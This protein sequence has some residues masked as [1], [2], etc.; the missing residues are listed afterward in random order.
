MKLFNSLYE[1]RNRGC[2]NRFLA[3]SDLGKGDQK[4]RVPDVDAGAEAVAD[5]D[6]GTVSFESALANCV[7][8]DKAKGQ[9]RSQKKGDRDDRPRGKS[10]EAPGRNK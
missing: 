8:D 3:Q 5:G 7:K 9:D 6:T 4:V 10:G 2:V 1:G